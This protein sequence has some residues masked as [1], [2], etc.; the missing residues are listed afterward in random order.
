[1]E[2]DDQQPVSA[3]APDIDPEK[4]EIIQNMCLFNDEFSTICY[5]GNI[6]AAEHT[7]RVITGRP[8]LKVNSVKAQFVL[9][10]L[11]GHGVRFD[12]YAT[13]DQQ[14]YDVEIQR[15]DEDASPLRA[16]YNSSMIDAN[17]L[18]KGTK[19]QNLPETYVIFITENDVLGAGLPL[20][21]AD[22]YI[23]ELGKQ[24]DD[25]AHIIYVNGKYDG[26]DPV[27][28]LMRDFRARDTDTMSDSPLRETAIRFKHTEGG[29]M[30][31]SKTIE[32]YTEKKIAEGR[33]KWKAEGTMNTLK[34]LVKKNVITLADAAKEAGMTPEAFK[35]MAML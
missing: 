9:P 35:K 18:R 7:L 2:P 34:S 33:D 24:L 32:E 16:R 3:I 15:T 13:T 8:S 1:M 25:K 29:L 5:D 10:N 30:K 17:T 11:K 20:Y 31:M 6:P 14:R 26:D 12:V 22:R 4:I 27:G 28:Q 23:V 19:P 21:H